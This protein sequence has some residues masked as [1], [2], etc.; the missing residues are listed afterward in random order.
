MRQTWHASLDK[1]AR[2]LWEGRACPFSVV[3]G[4]VDGRKASQ[5]CVGRVPDAHFKEPPLN[6]RALGES[7][8]ILYV[9][10]QIS[11]GAFNLGV[12]QQNLNG[13]QVASL[14]DPSSPKRPTE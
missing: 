6:L 8:R 10:A 4:V 14:L 12:P 13:A 3:D 1:F 9:D 11:N 7:E 5:K 2:P